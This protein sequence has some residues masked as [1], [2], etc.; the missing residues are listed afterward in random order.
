MGFEIGL[1]QRNDVVLDVPPDQDLCRRLAV[2]SSHAD[3]VLV[4]QPMPSCQRTA[5]LNDGLIGDG[6]VQHALAVAEGARSD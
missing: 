4:I 5:G 1:R 6:I 2:L 3:K